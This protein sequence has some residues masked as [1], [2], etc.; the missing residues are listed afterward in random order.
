[1]GSRFI[2]DVRKYINDKVKDEPSIIAPCPH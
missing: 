2:H 1:M